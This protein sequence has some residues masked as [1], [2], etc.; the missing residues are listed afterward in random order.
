MARPREVISS[1][2]S[3]SMDRLLMERKAKMGFALTY[4]NVFTR[5]HIGAARTRATSP[6]ANSSSAS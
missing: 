2:I 6:A 4:F 3:S 5:R 1:V